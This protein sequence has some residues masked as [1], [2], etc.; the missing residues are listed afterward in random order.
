MADPWVVT[1]KRN[2]GQNYIVLFVMEQRHEVM[3]AIGRWASDPDLTF[4][5]YDATQ[6]ARHV[7]RCVDLDSQ[8]RP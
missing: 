3:R 2:D 7:R 4:T 5:W 8:R 6:M 1:Y